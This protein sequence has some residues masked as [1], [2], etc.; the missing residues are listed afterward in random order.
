MGGTIARSIVPPGLLNFSLASRH[1][2][3]LRAG[4]STIAPPALSARKRW[5][6]GLRCD[7]HIDVRI[8]TA[9]SKGCGRSLASVRGYAT[10]L[11]AQPRCQP[12]GVALQVITLLGVAEEGLEAVIH[13][14]LD[15]A[16]KQSEAGLIGGEVDGGA[17]E[18]GD[19]YRVL[20]DA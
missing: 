4:L 9:L 19:D 1:S 17:A 11:D 7:R 14:L 6:D 15:V 5:Q 8:F 20:D 18:I 3:S 13:V 12:E 16:V 2:P 10:F